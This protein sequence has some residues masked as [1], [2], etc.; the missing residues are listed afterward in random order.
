MQRLNTGYF[1]QLGWQVHPLVDITMESK[2]DDWFWKLVIARN[3]LDAFTKESIIPAPLSKQAAINL[4]VVIENSLPSGGPSPNDMDK[5]IGHAVWDISRRLLEFESVLTAELMQIET[6]VTA[7][8]GIYDTK[9]LVE[10]A[11]NMFSDEVRKWLSEQA[12]ID[13]CQ[14]GRCLAFEIPTAAGFHLARA[15]ED[16]IRRY[17]AVVAKKPYDMEKQGHSWAK[18]ISALEAEGS[19]K[20]V[21]NALDQMRE[22]HRNPISHPDVNLSIDE[23]M[24]LVG[25][26]Q[27]A[28]VAMAADSQRRESESRVKS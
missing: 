13:I 1:Y 5:Q 2:W 15:V 7:Q 8:K 11:E 17:Y 18:Y 27:S 23:A 28:I 26:A 24:M 21:L 25:L 20:N 19:D 6:F 14:A 4:V 12:V 9:R 16:S 22:L 10:D 3:A